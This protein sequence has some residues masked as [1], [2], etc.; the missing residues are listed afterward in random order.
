MRD[1]HIFWMQY[2]MD[3]YLFL[4]L[5]AFIIQKYRVPNDNKEP[6]LRRPN[7][8]CVIGSTQILAWH[9]MCHLLPGQRGLLT[10]NPPGRKSKAPQNG[11]C[12][13]F[14]CIRVPWCLSQS[15]EDA[16][17]AA[18]EGVAEL[19]GAGSRLTEGTG[20]RNSLGSA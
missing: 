16:P 20:S 4:H 19:P 6:L 2:G 12:L 18:G 8:N 3:H 9:F 1:F 5:I 7:S 14:P 11:K 10:P 15:R 13:C 17:A